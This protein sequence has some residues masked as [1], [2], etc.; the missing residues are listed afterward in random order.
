MYEPVRNL[1]A[2]AFDGLPAA[3]VDL[4]AEAAAGVGGA[5]TAG[6]VG[7]AVAVGVDEGHVR[8]VHVRQ[9]EAAAETS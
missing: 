9:G 8:R 4:V 2:R 5:G 6:V 7:D 3:A 1:H